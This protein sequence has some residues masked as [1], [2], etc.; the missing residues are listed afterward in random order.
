MKS[1]PTEGARILEETIKGV[2]SDE[3]FQI[4]HDMA[5]YHHENTMEVAIQAVCPEMTFLSPREL[6]LSLTCTM[7]FVQADIIKKV[8]LR[9]NRW[10]SSKKAAVRT[11]IPTSRKSSFR[12]STRSNPYLKFDKS[13][14]IPL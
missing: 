7:P 10:Q 2:E 13:A 12:T 5:L 14:L 4:A 8:F 3:Y 6:W 1:H 9:K 11:L